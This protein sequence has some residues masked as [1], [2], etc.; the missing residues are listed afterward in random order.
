[1]ASR[2]ALSS[3]LADLP[4]LARFSSLRASSFLGSGL[5]FG[6][7][8]AALGSSFGFGAALGFFGGIQLYRLVPQLFFPQQATNFFVAEFTFP[9]GTSIATT[10]WRF[11]L[12]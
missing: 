7:S 5:G 3:L 9:P 6:A 10:R 1:M 8:S 4:F 12:S 2:R 11:W